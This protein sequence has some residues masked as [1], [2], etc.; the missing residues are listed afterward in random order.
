MKI[1][2]VV[3]DYQRVGVGQTRYVGELA[4]RFC[5]DHEV[6]VFAN[7]IEGDE[8]LNI[9][10]HHVPAWRKNALTGLLSFA[11]ASTLQV[12]NGFDIVHSQ[13]FCGFYGNVFTA[14]ICNRAWH[15]ALEKLDHGVT[16]REGI[17]NAFATTFE[18]STYRRASNSNVIAVSSRVAEDLRKFYHCP[19]PMRV[20]H[21]GVDL[22]TFSPENRPRMR[23]EVRGELGL[24]EKD[25]VFL[26][27][28]HLR[29]GAERCVRALARLER[30]VLVCVARTPSDPYR[31]LAKELGL[32]DR[33]RLLSFSQHV[34]RFYAAGDALLLPSPYDAFGMVV[35]EG[36]ASGLP[37]VVSREAGASEL[38]RNG[39]NGYVL[40][41]VTNEA[42]LAGRMQSLL[43]D[44]DGAKRLGCAARKTVE[45]LTW[46]WV[47]QE[48]MQVYEDL[49]TRKLQRGLRPAVP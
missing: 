21:H 42:E 18:Y 16:L 47:A 19:A 22:E 43:A 27:V 14:H 12:G 26:Y 25:F 15:Q 31:A 17:F 48:T 10:F 6:H 44:P 2:F 24:T 20:I 30:G 40:E 1:A 33:V 3:H 46:D 34:E 36:M 11:A 49:L 23:S 39:L 37:V 32:G 28:G 9:R 5:R 41:D 8:D 29:K 13:G 4:R 38:I 7:R 45:S 35:T